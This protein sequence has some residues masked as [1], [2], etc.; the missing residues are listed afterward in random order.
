M[1]EDLEEAFVDFVREN[2]KNLYLLAYSYVKNEQD[3]LDIVQESIHKGWQALSSI[4]KGTSM[5]SWFYKIV[6]RTAI[7]FLRKMKRIQIMEDEKLTFFAKK[8]IDTYENTDLENALDQLPLQMRE[9]IVLR[10]FEDLTIESVAKVL[11]IP[12]STAKSRLYKA[13]Q[14]LKIELTDLEEGDQQWMNV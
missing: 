6:V 10:Y 4:K 14:L 1:W 5:K 8:Q 3:A 2:K 7:D 9:V 13:L 12:V 11:S